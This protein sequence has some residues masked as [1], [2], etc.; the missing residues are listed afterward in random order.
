VGNA[1]AVILAW[2]DAETPLPDVVP[3]EHPLSIGFTGLVYVDGN[4]D[5][6]VVVPPASP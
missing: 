4:G 3:Y 6:A 5:G 1:D 2:A